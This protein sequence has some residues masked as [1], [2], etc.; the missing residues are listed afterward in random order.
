[1]RPRSSMS[2]RGAVLICVRIS[3]R[4]LVRRSVGPLVGRSVMLSSK[5]M[6]NKLLRI[7]Y[8]VSLGYLGLSYTAFFYWKIILLL[9]VYWKYYYSMFDRDKT[10]GYFEY[11]RFAPTVHMIQG[12][13]LSY[14]I[15]QY[16]TI[17]QKTIKVL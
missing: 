12:P 17:L 3:I 5:L 13:R 15:I 11:S 7:L 6:K 10:E 4:G 2:V 8:D 14:T 9:V 1:M 16:Y